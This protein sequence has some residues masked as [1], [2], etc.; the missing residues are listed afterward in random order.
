MA[1][2]N[3]EYILQMKHIDMFFPGVKALKDVDNQSKA[4]LDAIQK[5]LADLA[6]YEGEKIIT[7]LTDEISNLKTEITESANS[8]EEKIWRNI[9]RRLGSN[10]IGYSK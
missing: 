7:E 6:V 9:S 8:N 3:D 1:L 2:Q 10:Q 4:V 5:E